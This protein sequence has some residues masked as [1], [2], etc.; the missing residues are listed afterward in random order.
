VPEED[1]PRT[2]FEFENRFAEE[3][4]CFKYLES[5]RWPEGFL[6]PQCGSLEAWKMTR[7]L[8]LCSQCRKQVSILAGTAFQDSHLQIQTWF[9]AMWH[10]CS[11]KNGMSALGLQRVLGLGSYR[12]A[13]LMLHKLRRAMVRPHREKLQG[14]VEVD[15][16][17]WGAAE[18]GVTTGRQI[19][20][21]ALIIIAAEVSGRGIGRIRMQK[22]PSFDRKSLHNFIQESIEEGSTV[23]TDGLNSYRELSGYKHDRKIQRKQQKGQVLL[24]RAHLAISLFKRWMLGTLQGGVPH[25]YLEDYLNEFVFRF[26]R[27]KS[28]SR[29]KLFLRL[30]Q[31]ATQI[32]PVPYK[33]ISQTRQ[34]VVG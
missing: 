13:W 23:C 17:Y 4:A 2:L 9:R 20:S 7:G 11:Q 3:E 34:I 12:S 24:S 16:T 5:L 33:I 26:N 28:A 21:K 31:Q 10:I 25:K 14:V 29:G 8:W 22:I 30:A 1:Y 19:V 18:T 6:C 27:R 32:D 15:E